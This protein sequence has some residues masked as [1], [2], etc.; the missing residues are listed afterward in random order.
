MTNHR[1]L[2][3][4]NHHVQ[5]SLR[6]DGEDYSSVL[7]NL[8][9][10]IGDTAINDLMSLDTQINDEEKRIILLAL[11]DELESIL[12]L[13]IRVMKSGSI[14]FELI[15]RTL[16]LT[17]IVPA[18]RKAGIEPFV[19]VPGSTSTI[20]G[21]QNDIS[22]T[23]RACINI[24]RLYGWIVQ[25]RK[26]SDIEKSKTGFVPDDISSIIIAIDIETLQHMRSHS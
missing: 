11:E 5:R 26:M 19:P 24:L 6:L 1:L 20:E 17:V 13:Y 23:V 4:R 2:E 10:F 18:L 3:I 12:R 25:I 21:C 14:G 16:Y 7:S 9:C 22:W 15:F 8:D